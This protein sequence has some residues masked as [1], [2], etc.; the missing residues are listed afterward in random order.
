MLE[1]KEKMNATCDTFSQLKKEI[2]REK[3]RKKERKKERH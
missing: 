3:E 1:F 2:K